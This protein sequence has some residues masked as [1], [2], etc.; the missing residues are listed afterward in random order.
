MKRMKAFWLVAVLALNACAQSGTLNSDRKLTIQANDGGSAVTELGYGIAVNK[1]SSL[2][3]RWY[4]INDASCPVDLGAVGIKP[5]YKS[6]EYGGSY[7]FTPVG[8]LTPKV[9]L[10]AVEVN[11]AQFDVWGNPER[12]LAA[13]E[14]RD[15]QAGQSFKIEG[16]W[17]ATENDVS[18][19]LTSVV[20]VRNAMTADGKIWRADLDKIATLL[21]TV[22][23]KVSASG[24]ESEPRKEP[25]KK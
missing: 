8:N 10:S 5:I 7:S 18:E 6:R 14:I 13:N 23:L 22:A 12:T 2:H 21:Q 4:V 19:Q 16:G 24:L 20:F 11:F 15:L 17:Y 25:E 1:G 3:R 9:A